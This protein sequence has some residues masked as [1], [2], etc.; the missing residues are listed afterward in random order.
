M[1]CSVRWRGAFLAA[2]A[3]VLAFATDGAAQATGTIEG[4]VTETGSGRPLVGAQ[5]F[6]AGTTVGSVTNERGEY[7][8]TG[9]P[10][11]QVE[12]RVRLIGYSPINRTVVVTAGQTITQDIQVGVSALQL[13]QVVVTGTGSQV[14]VKK[15]GNTIATIQP[16]AFAPIS[17]PSQLLQARDAGVSIL[18]ASGLAGEGSRIRI[19]GNASLSMSNEP[20]VFVDGVRINTAGGGMG[21]G[22]GGSVSRLDDIDPSSIDRVEV[23]KGAAAATLYGTEASNGVIQIFTKKGASG[24]ARWTFNAEQAAMNFDVDRIKPN[25]GV[26]KYD[27][28]A[29]RLGSFFGQQV[30][31][32]QPFCINASD[33]ILGV[34][35][36]TT[37][38]GSVTG[39]TSG[40][41]YFASGRYE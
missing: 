25:C 17:T 7:R 10:A 35:M 26:A 39:G 33:D 28:A 16:P 37:V 9:A 5:V 27:T 14:E 12:L 34:G 23:L 29:S 38:N 19:R 22:G 15:L 36:G 30:T 21:A 8:V 13:E 3:F 4:K 40:F 20:I 1:M 2:A 18:P 24:Q 32:Y 31:A 6:V 11:R 41:T